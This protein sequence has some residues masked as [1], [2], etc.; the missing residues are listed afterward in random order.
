ME[1]SS[2]PSLSPLSASILEK[3][4]LFVWHPFTQAQTAPHPIPISHGKGAYL[5]GFDGTAYFD[6]MSS[7]WVTLHGHSH[8]AI[9]S[10]I[11]SQ[12]HCLEHVMFTNFTHA[13]AVELAERLVHLLNKKNG[14]V[15]YS[16]NGSTA[17]ETALK[18]ALQY[19]YNQ[20]S[21][22]PKKKIISF[23]NGYHGDTFGAMASS[24]ITPFNRPFWP[25]LFEIHQITPPFPGQEDLSLHQLKSLLQQGDTACFLFEPLIQGVTGMHI[26]SAK[27]LNALIDLCHQHG[28]ITIADEV[29]TG[30]GRTG[31]LFACDYLATQPHI[32]C[33]AKCLTG[34]FLPLGATVCHGDIFDGFL[35][36]SR[37]KA[38]LHG[39]S[40]CGNPIACA[41]A[42]ANLDLLEHPS[43]ILQRQSIELLH[44]N[45]LNSIANHPKLS[46]AHVIGTI[47]TLEYRSSTGQNYFSS[48][49]D[50][51]MNF[52]LQ[53][54][55]IVRPMGNVL[56][57]MPPYC[58]N[59]N[60][61]IPVYECIKSTLENLP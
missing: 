43:C 23:L 22:H 37:E 29:L 13:P 38:L 19:H 31:P 16:D 49:R 8:P 14:R 4:E 60:D 45:F 3:D 2:L 41:A 46:R 47:L 52:F 58:S 50:S 56:I 27:G 30:F 33:L 40:F 48:L 53:H 20:S 9:A 21:S 57:I 55:I 26:H 6:A 11:A 28:V 1:I 18:I 10:R 42:L 15:F 25:F 59:A 54:N 44:K 39:H 7:W 5:F 36:E 17:V 35:S 34:G 12:A 24:G 51:L 61:L 32:T